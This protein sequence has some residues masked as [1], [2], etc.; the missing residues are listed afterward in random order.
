M[1]NFIK[2]SFLILILALASSCNNKKETQMTNKH[3]DTTWYHIPVARIIYPF[4]SLYNYDSEYEKRDFLIL[5]VEKDIKF[6]IS[7]REPYPDTTFLKCPTLSPENSYSNHILIED[8]L[9]SIIYFKD[10]EEDIKHGEKTIEALYNELME[11][12][13]LNQNTPL[14]YPLNGR[15]ENTQFR[16]Y[17]LS[18]DKYSSYARP[19]DFESLEKNADVAYLRTYSSKLRINEEIKKNSNVLLV[20]LS[21]S[22]EL[23]PDIIKVVDLP[24]NEK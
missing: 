14:I 1:D 18:K 24:L 12:I 2:S 17:I 4:D 6:K 11:I 3:N 10:P 5:Q 20:G 13:K 19:Y 16:G 7:E 23:N 8:Y 21:R 15:R 9:T 22:F